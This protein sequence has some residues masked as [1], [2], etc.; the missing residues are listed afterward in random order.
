M[1]QPLCRP[2]GTHLFGCAIFCNAALTKANDFFDDFLRPWYI[3]SNGRVTPKTSFIVELRAACDCTAACRFLDLLFFSLPIAPADRNFSS[4]S[5][6]SKGAV[7]TRRS[8]AATCSRGRCGSDS[9]HEEVGLVLG[10]FADFSRIA[11]SWH[12]NTHEDSPKDP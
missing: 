3:P 6:A 11:V 12:P 10:C 1:P 7:V 9:R 2:F 4:N 8:R 5:K